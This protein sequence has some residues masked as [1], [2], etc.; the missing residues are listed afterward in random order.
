MDKY[1]KLRP[2]TDLELCNC[3]S[4][5]GI[6]LLNMLTENPLHCSVCRKEIEPS[7][8][9]LEPELV[10]EIARWSSVY[11]ALY[12][13]WFN[14]GQYENWAKE[15]LLN[16]KGQVNKLGMNLAKKLS[17]LY[18]TYYWCFFDV[19]DGI[20]E[21]CPNCRRQLS[22]DFDWGTGNCRECKIML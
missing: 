9:E 13:L 12:S 15:Q 17:D 5:S 3:E 2:F 22:E 10:D 19:D 1:Q 16:M 21:F 4:I 11:N 8:L 7:R 6:V 14:S 20:P 18:P